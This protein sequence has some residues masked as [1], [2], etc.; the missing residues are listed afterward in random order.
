MPVAAR[1]RASKR[2]T[3]I[4][5]IAR[6][7]LL[8]ELKLLESRAR[9]GS[10][11]NLRLRPGRCRSVPRRQRARRLWRGRLLLAWG[12]RTMLQKPCDR[13]EQAWNYNHLGTKWPAVHPGAARPP[14]LGRPAAWSRRSR[15]TRALPKRA[16]RKTGWEVLLIPATHSPPDV[17]ACVSLPRAGADAARADRGELRMTQMGPLSTGRALKLLA[18]AQQW[19]GVQPIRLDTGRSHVR[20]IGTVWAWGLTMRKT[21]RLRRG[22]RTT[23]TRWVPRLLAGSSPAVPTTLNQEDSPLERGSRTP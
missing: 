1:F 20:E 6:D 2:S 22:S 9:G 7:V 5:R 15:A 18:G 16:R 13:L 10:P 19:S 8:R 11:V 14:A 12:M 3:S 23:S 4:V 17:I 21:R